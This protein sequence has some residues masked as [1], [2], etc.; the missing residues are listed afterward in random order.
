MLMNML[1]QVLAPGMQHQRHTHLTVQAPRITPKLF[2]GCRY[3]LEQE[4]VDDLGVQLYPAIERMW[5]G[6]HQVIVGNRQDVVA[7]AF[8]PSGA[9]RFLALGTVA[10][11]ARMEAFLGVAAVATDQRLPSQHRSVRQQSMLVSTFACS[12]LR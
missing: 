1:A 7:S 6:K 10:V 5:Q 2:Q 9:G 4:R 3:S 11:A 8:Q 12:G